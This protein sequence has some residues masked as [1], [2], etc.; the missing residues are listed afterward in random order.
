MGATRPRP[1]VLDAG[2]LIALERG[3][4]KMRALVDVAARASRALV[5]PAAVVAQVWR[6][7][8]RQVA[9]ARL[10]KMENVEVPPLDEGCCRAVGALCGRAGTRDVVDALVV[11]TARHL[12]ALVISSDRGDLLKIDPALAVEEL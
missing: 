1:V 4:K 2:A 5:V 3:D 11:L 10:L 9:L 8:S 7:G 12:G 6:D